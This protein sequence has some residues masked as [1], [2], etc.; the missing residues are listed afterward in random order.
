MR[1]TPAPEESLAFVR[2]C[3]RARGH[4]FS[5]EELVR[6]SAA[7]A[8][9][10]SYTARCEHALDPAGEKT[11]GSFREALARATDSGYLPPD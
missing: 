11:E 5:R 6:V 1:L 2:A 9:A 10:V 8:Y 4:P 3:E 7:A